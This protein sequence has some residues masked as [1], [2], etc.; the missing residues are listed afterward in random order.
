MS[1]FIP[2]AIYRFLLM[3]AAT[4]CCEPNL[5][6]QPQLPMDVGTVVNGFQDDFDGADLQANWVVAGSDAF[7]VSGGQLHVSPA[8]G[9][10][11][12]LLYELP[13][14]DNTVQEVLARVRVVSFGT[15]D[16]VG[17][18][19]GVGIDPT[20][21][22]GINYLF[23]ENT[24][25][26]QSALHLALLNDMIAWGPVQN[27]VWQVNTWYWVRLRQQ[28]NATSQGGA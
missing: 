24:S 2:S 1:R 20:S 17:G 14:Y 5:L 16:L 22:Q 9:D 10:P 3:F 12:H 23:R 19:V 11:N 25:D 26:G 18:G 6:G 7:T 21:T 4:L 15:G 13:G 28:P 27:F 8:T